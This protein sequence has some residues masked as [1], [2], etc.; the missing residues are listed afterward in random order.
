MILADQDFY[1][2]AKWMAACNF[3]DD[4]KLLSLFEI[5]FLLIDEHRLKM[6]EM[7]GGRVCYE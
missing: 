5:T 1:E 4:E 3:V 6:I 7:K 2:E